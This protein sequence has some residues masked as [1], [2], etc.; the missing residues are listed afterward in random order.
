MS[1]RKSSG[2]GGGMARCAAGLPAGAGLGQESG[3]AAP[4]ASVVPLPVLGHVIQSS[5][6][7]FTMQTTEEAG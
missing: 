3:A 1:W 2:A 6:A 5:S 4:A 7:V